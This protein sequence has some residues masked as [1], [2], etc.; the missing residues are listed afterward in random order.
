MEHKRPSLL[1]PLILITIGVLFLLVNLGYLPL[2]LWEIAFRFWPLILILIGVEMLVGRRSVIGGFVVT[3]LWLALVAG[4][5][6]LALTTGLTGATTV[7][8]TINQP[9]GEITRATIDLNI[10]FASVAVKALGEDT[11]DLMRGTFRHAEGIQIGKVFNTLENEGRLTLREERINFFTAGM[12]EARWDIA[13]N[14]TIPLTLR[15]DGGLGRADLDLSVLTMS[16]LEVNAGIGRVHI[17]T[18]QRG[19]MTMRLDGGVGDV[20]VTIPEGV[21][22]R[23]QVDRG[24][25]TVRVTETRFPKTGNV[26]QSTNWERAEHQITI[27]IS[28]G[29]GTVEVR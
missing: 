24:I 17:T 10:G 20:H 13:L 2:S 14:S 29:I 26:Y 28:G 18:P 12:T 6:W 8:E 1:G 3:A 11:T 16:A 5:V 25:G 21:A 23:V 4:V 7:T 9:V 22:A 15:L 19:K 27:Q